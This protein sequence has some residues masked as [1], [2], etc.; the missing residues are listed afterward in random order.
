MASVFPVC[1]ASL[2]DAPPGAI[3][4][5]EREDGRL[6]A[7]VTDQSENNARSLVFLNAKFDRKPPVIYAE[8]WRVEDACLLYTGNLQFELGM[9]GDEVSPN[10]HD[11][12]RTAGV[13]VVIGSQ[14]FIR[15]GYFDNQ[16]G[17]GQLVNIQTGA[18]FT[19]RQTPN[20]LWTFSKWTLWQEDPMNGQ[21]IEICSLDLT[22]RS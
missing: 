3:V 17:V 21:K 18:L 16:F 6:I 2:K 15:A 14:L 13:V 5:I 22:P 9:Q 8:N 1:G 12:W 20:E 7:L 19:E 10:G 11:L 4:R